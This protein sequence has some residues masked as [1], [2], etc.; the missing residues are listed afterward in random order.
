[1]ALVAPRR[2]HGA[3]DLVAGAQLAAADLGGR[4]VHVVGRLALVHA[5]EAAA[6]GEDVEHAAGGLLLAHGL[7]GILGLLLDRLAVGLLRL[8]VGIGLGLLLDLRRLRR[9]V[10]LELL[11]LLRV[12]VGV[13]LD[14]RIV[15]LST[16]P[17]PLFGQD[18]PDEVRLAHAAE[19]LDAKLGRDGVQVRERAG[20]EFLSL[21]D[22]HG[23]AE[24]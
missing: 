18:R 2:A 21:Q 20:L 7:G 5:H 24:P 12:V 1:M 6:V 16:V 10:G 23:R 13:D 11:G 22:G 14:R 3:A 4:D 19:A 17:C 9:P 15:V 8:R